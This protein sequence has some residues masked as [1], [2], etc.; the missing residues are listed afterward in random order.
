MRSNWSVDYVA[1]S[2]R[3]AP[4]EIL[5]CAAP[6]HNVPVILTPGLMVAIG[7]N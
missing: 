7:G 4:L 1:A 6:C 3:T 2:V 5:H